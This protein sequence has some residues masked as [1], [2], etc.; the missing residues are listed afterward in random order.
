MSKSKNAYVCNGCGAMSPK[1]SGQC[2][3][4]GDWNSL[5]QTVIM[6]QPKSERLTGYA[7]GVSEVLLMK[8]VPCQDV[9]RTSTSMDEFDRVLG[10]GLVQGSVILIGGDPGIGKSTLLLQ[11]L[12]YLSQTQKTLYITGEES[13]QQVAMRAKRLSLYDQTLKMYSETEVEQICRVAQKEA[14]TVMVIDSIQTMYLA[15]VP[16]APGGVSQV[17]ESAATLARFAKKNGITMFLVGHVTKSGDVAGPRVLEHIVDTVIYVEGQS[18]SRFRMLRGLKNRFGSVNELGVF[19]MTETGLKEIKNPSGIF[20]SRTEQAVPGSI[21]TAIWEGTRPLLVE[22][23]A[24]VDDSH[25]PNPRRVCVG[26]DSNRLS[27]LLAVLHRHGGLMTAGSDVYLNV[28]GGVRVS[29]T[30]ADLASLFAI[31]SSFKNKAIHHG[32]IAFGEVGLSGEI[33]PVPSGAERLREASKQGFTHAIVPKANA[34]KK[35][36]GIKVIAV[37]TLSEALDAMQS[38]VD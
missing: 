4:C 36:I 22:I 5:T 27:L 34:P 3:D 14:P 12:C 23:Q 8:D 30:A 29:E 10:G 38:L 13:L 37:K 26:L 16:G 9:P 31:V 20:L 18:D 24:L 11:T 6:A 32:A 21:A 15:E 33:R 1:W 17:R 35:D 25:M 28:V 19:A 7:S 2:A